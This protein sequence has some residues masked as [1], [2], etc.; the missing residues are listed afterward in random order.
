MPWKELGIDVVVE[1]SGVFTK[2]DQLQK[3]IEAGAKK[4][5]LTAPADAAED[6]DITMVLGVNEGAY[7]PETHHLISNASCTTNCLAPLVK[8]IHEDFGIESGIAV[9]THGLYGRS[10]VGRRPP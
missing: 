4:V 7:V 3:H 2:R 9:T 10:A 1:A 6:V 8:V 5:I